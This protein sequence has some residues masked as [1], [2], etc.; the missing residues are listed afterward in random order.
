MYRRFF[1]LTIFVL[2]NCH[3]FAQG[4]VYSLDFLGN[5]TSTAHPTDY[6]NPARWSHHL[7]GATHNSNISF[8]SFGQ[9]SSSGVELF[10]ETGDLS[11]FSDEVNTAITNGNAHSLIDLATTSGQSMSF[12]GAINM[13]ANF[14]YISLMTMI[15]P[16][17][18]WL[19]EVHNV[20]LTDASGNW[21]TTISIDVYATDAGTDSGTTY[22]SP[23]LDTNPKEPM[24]SL[25]NTY[26]FSD[27]IVA[28]FVFNLDRVLSVEGVSLENNISIYPNPCKGTIHIR[29]L[30]NNFI[31]SAEIYST[32]G[33]KLKEFNNITNQK[34]LSFNSLK[35]GIYFLKLYFSEGNITKKLIME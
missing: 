4:A 16:S 10:A 33:R 3:S 22:T 12:E 27:Q 32:T 14:P 34:L 2:L 23:N 24:H 20:K 6:P 8:W 15:A 1:S 5:W 18:D 35:S 7:V 25:Q 29:N 31:K 26:P 13:D 28:T 17:P 19:G 21:K 9:I 11:V 30:G